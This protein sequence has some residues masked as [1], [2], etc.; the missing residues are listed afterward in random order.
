MMKVKGINT[1]RVA[2]GLTLAALIGDSPFLFLAP[3]A[4][5]CIRITSNALETCVIFPLLVWAEPMLLTYLHG[6]H[7]QMSEEQ[8]DAENENDERHAVIYDHTSD[9]DG[10]LSVKISWA[11]IIATATIFVNPFWRKLIGSCNQCV[12]TQQRRG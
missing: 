1:S 10:L 2:T 7:S 4:I 8:T 6:G 3:M 11:R 9:H 5:N 12:S